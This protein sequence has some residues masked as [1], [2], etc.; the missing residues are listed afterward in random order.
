MPIAE[1]RKH[2]QPMYTR[3]SIQSF[4]FVFSHDLSLATRDRGM[5]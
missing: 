3:A 5:A 2:E 1:I 4:S